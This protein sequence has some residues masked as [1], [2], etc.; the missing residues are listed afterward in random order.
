MTVW[1]ATPALDA[2]KNILYFVLRR[3]DPFS[4]EFFRG[5]VDEVRIYNHA[6][7]AADITA[8]MTTPVVR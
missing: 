2:P 8:D 3:V 7:S 4:G 5:V 1:G 6:L